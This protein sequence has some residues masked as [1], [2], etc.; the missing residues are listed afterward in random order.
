MT[1][2]RVTVETALL[3]FQAS[4]DALIDFFKENPYRV[5]PLF[6]TLKQTFGFYAPDDAAN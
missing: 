2:F 4:K 6:K 1:S 5:D 3:H